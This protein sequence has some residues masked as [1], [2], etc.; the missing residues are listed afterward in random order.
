M[1]PYRKLILK[2]TENEVQEELNCN[3]TV[4]ITSIISSN[5][6]QWEFV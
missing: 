4:C 6:R 2:E 1:L 5:E 3:Q